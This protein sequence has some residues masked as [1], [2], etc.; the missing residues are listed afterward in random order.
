MFRWTL[1]LPLLLF[2]FALG[3]RLLGVGWGLKNELHNASYHPDE[4]VIF[5]FSRA[6]EPSQGQFTPHFYN[7][8][9]LY[10][11][12]LRISSDIVTTYTGAPTLPGGG[13]SP[14]HPE[15]TDWDWVSRCT[16]A[17][18]YLSCL[19][20]A[21]TVLVLYLIGTRLFGPLGGFVA[22]LTLAVAPAHVVHSRFQS[23]D[24]LA[25]FFLAISTFYALKLLRH[26][27]DPD[28][29]PDGGLKLV[30]LSGLF[31]GLSMG[32]KYTG[33]LALLTLFVAIAFARRPRAILEA[34][35]G[36]FVALISFIVT[37]PGC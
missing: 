35:V 14:T 3:I 12:L 25:T 27:E 6:I 7:Y 5:G 4:A 29:S 20:G 32:T 8:G 22:A 26:G 23:V 34:G 31:A 10:L 24:V 13:W 1:A 15:R 21:G 33:I 28:T 36:V 30:V 18:R 17:G 9:T 2:A 16:L 11:T 19:A 37:T